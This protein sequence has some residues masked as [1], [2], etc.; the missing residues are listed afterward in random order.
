MRYV[1]ALVCRECGR[2]YEVTPEHACSY[3][4]GPLEVT[5]DYDAIAASSLRMTISQGPASLWRYAPLLPD[6]GGTR[7]DLGAG[8]TKLRPAPR[9]AAELGLKKLWLKNDGGNPTHSFKDR[10]VSVALSVARHFGYDVAACASTGNLANSVAAHAAA[11]GMRSVV[12]IPQGLE[13]AKLAAT[14]VYGGEIV[15]VEGSYDD[16]N[17]LCAELAG[18]K[19]WAFVN[20]N[21]RPFYA[22]GSKTLAFEIAE[23]LDWRTPAA[24]IAPI[25]AGS[26]LTKLAKGFRELSDVGLLA[27]GGTALY[28]AQA[29]GCSPVARAF[30]AGDDDITPVKPDTVARSLAI[31]DPADGRYAL[32]AARTTGGAIAEVPESAVADGML[33]LAR[34]EGIFTETAG[35][36]V[37]SA[38]EHMVRS[39]TISTEDETVLLITGVGLKTIEALPD[40]RATHRIRPTVAELERVFGAAQDSEH[41]TD[42]LARTAETVSIS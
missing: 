4:F 6:P 17:R 41:E 37:V 12:F 26:L 13:R 24:L 19:P 14:S 35:G 29:A 22:E 1:E 16:A 11:A 36:V 23:Q 21:L 32:K 25:A 3:C 20:V 15:E 40:A 2:R 5:Y 30:A 27:G 28:G 18:S 8:L 7:V 9:L 39:G 33:L 34:T 38:L 10:V 31:G 42:L